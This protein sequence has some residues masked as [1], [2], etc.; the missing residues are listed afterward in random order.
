M[1]ENNYINMLYFQALIHV[2]TAY[3][4]CDRREVQEVIYPPPLHPK[5]LLD[6]V[7]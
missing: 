4:N 6:A 7:E 1:D 5:K 3:A 2:S